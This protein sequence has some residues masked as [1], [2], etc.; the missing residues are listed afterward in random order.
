MLKH[1]CKEF[2]YRHSFVV[3]QQHFL[4]PGVQESVSPTHT[5]SIWIP[6][7]P[8]GRCFYFCFGVC[9]Q[10]SAGH[11]CN[12]T[13]GCI[14]VQHSALQQVISASLK[15]IAIKLSKYS[16]PQMLLLFHGLGRFKDDLNNRF[17]TLISCRHATLLL[18]LLKK[19]KKHKLSYCSFHTLSLMNTNAFLQQIK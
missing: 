11:F 15:G 9:C 3:K 1:S 12:G 13:K 7:L 19:N 6:Q 2:K 16:S 4:K 18:Q 17:L 5:F 14:V 10:F 8:V